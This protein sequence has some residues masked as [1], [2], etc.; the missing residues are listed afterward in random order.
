VASATLSN[1]SFSNLSA[2]TPPG[3]VSTEYIRATM[4]PN[5][6]PYVQ[7][8]SADISRQLPMAMVLDVGY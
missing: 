6:I 2:G 3:T 8:W 1:A 7:Q 4:L 5:L